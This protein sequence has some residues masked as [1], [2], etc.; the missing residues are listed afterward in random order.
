[1]KR[2]FSVVCGITVIGLATVGC[3]KRTPVVEVSV[4]DSGVTVEEIAV[5]GELDLAWPQWRGGVGG[6]ANEDAA[7][8]SAL[9]TEWN[10]ESNV[11]WQADVPGR[12][13]SSPIVVGDLVVIGSATETPAEQFVLAYDRNDGRELWKRVV[14]SGGLPS[15]RAV[16]RK[17]THAN[18][19]I[20]SDGV[21]LVTAHLNSDHVWATALDMEGELLWQTD[22]GAF[23]SKFGYA[24]SPVLYK[25][26]VII[27]ADNSGGGYL[28]G[29]DVRTGEIAWRRSRGN[30]SS[31]SSPA[32]VTVDGVDQVVISGGDRLASYAPATGEMLWETPCIAEATCGT[33][34]ATADRIY[35][36]GGYPEKETICV[37][38]KGKQ[39]WSN[40]TGLYEPSLVTDGKNL[41]AVSDDG[42]AYCWDAVDGKQH[43]KKR[44]GGNFSS[45]PVIA[46]GNVYVSDLSGND[47]VFQAGAEKYQLVAKNRLG[48][49]C[50]ASPA[51][52]GDAILFR[53]GVGQGAGRQEKLFC[54]ANES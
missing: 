22:I 2:S 13:H 52:A 49:D 27:A 12:G 40:R 48:D 18:G 17:A 1:M 25:S 16:H 15:A 26:L 7:T 23:V 11:R 41:F 31:Y 6:R 20:A 46:G 19:T 36:S 10:A 39:I 3:G 50:Y 30:V 53:V 43:W 33:A 45:S 38:G 8:T 42:V 54:I 28:V 51:V 32:L 9:P 47:Y 44:L 29:L 5:D 37:D 21:R 35:A 24:P 34:I 14:H 4:N